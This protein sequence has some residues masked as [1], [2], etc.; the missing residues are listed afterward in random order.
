MGKTN[1]VNEVLFVEMLND[2]FLCQLNHTP[3][4]CNNVLDLVIISVP[5]HVRLTEILP[6]EQSSV[7]TDHNAISF[8]FTAFIKAPRKS[9][10]TVYDYAKGDLNGLR[11]ALKSTD[12]PSL[13]S[14]SD[15]IDNDWQR[16]KNTFLSIISAFIPR[17]VIKGR[18]PLPWINSRKRIDEHLN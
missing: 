17:K 11:D 16:W 12:L 7:F 3:T 18:N 1:G 8:D 2:H 13:I 10:R 15:N 9:V 14:D 5:N 6:P 4:R